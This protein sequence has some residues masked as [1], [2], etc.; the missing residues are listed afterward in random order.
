MLYGTVHHKPFMRYLNNLFEEPV[1]IM[2]I[3]SVAFISI[4]LI[5]FFLCI[6][7]ISI[8][9]VSLG[10]LCCAFSNFI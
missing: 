2:L 10:L 6:F 3:T 1:F 5:F 4:A 7:I 9:L 8:F